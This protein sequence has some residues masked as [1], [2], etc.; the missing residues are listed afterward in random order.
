MTRRI[1]RAAQPFEGRTIIEIGPGPGGLT[2]ALML[3]GA[4]P[5]IA[6][7]RDARC[8]TA[9][10]PLVEAA[11][12]RLKVVE[13]DALAIDEAGLGEAPRLI[14]ANL[15][16]NIATPLILKWLGRPGLVER[17]VVMIQK[18]V[19]ERLI[20]RPGD[21]AYGR[22]SVRVHWVADTEILFDVSPRAF[23]P[24][25]KVVSSVIRLTPR[26]APLCAAPLDAFEAVLKA[27]FGQRRKMLRAALRGLG[28]DALALLGAAG[29]AP[30]ARAE[31]LSTEDFCALARALAARQGHGPI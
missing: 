17:A 19:A 7:E 30:T 6:V 29:I 2:R 14:V 31:T 21:E 1:A 27:A 4:A 26:P 10:A 25:P 12:G 18:E 3:E 28:V 11:A 20:A 8:L 23:V 9:L 24:P 15:P 16:Y 22:L 5:V 13:A